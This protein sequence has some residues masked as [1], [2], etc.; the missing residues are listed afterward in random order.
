[1]KLHQPYKMALVILVLLFGNY[2]QPQA[3]SFVLQSVGQK[4]TPQP[5]EQN[6]P[7]YRI[8]KGDKLSIKFL[9]QPELSDAGIVVRPDGR[10]SLAMVDEIQA[11]GLTAKELKK[12]LE[13]AY[14]EILLDPE[15]TVSITEFVA[16]RVFVG[17]QVAKPA[18][19]DLRAGQTLMQAIILAGGFT[20]EAHRKYVLHARPVSDRELKVVAVDVTK[21]LKPGEKNADVLLQDGDYVFVPNSKLSKFS[22]IVNAFRAI[23]PGYGIQF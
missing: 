20:P 15:I 13:K 2:C 22:N 1:M 16:P 18:S 9:Y 3:Q 14:R 6:A 23:V 4:T 10:I 8:R 21:L 19:Y 7:E 17:G 11:E 12:A 5:A